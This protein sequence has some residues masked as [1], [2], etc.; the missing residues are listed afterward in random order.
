MAERTNLHVMRCTLTYEITTPPPSYFCHLSPHLA[1][2]PAAGRN[3]KG[4][5]A[6]V[7]ACTCATVATYACVSF[8]GRRVEGVEEARRGG[9]GGGIEGG[10]D[11]G[12]AREEQAAWHEKRSSA[13]RF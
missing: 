2:H 6:H 11:G 13:P 5:R 7:H 3:A 4:E 8:A 12:R 9:L 10:G 1:F